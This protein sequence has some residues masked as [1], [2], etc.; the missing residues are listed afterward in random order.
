MTGKITPVIVEFQGV[1]RAID[2]DHAG[3]LPDAPTAESELSPS[4]SSTHSLVVLS[5]FPGLMPL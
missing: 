1:G 2:R 4:K 5:L 3:C